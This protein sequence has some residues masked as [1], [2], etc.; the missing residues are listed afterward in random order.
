MNSK[1]LGV[2]LEVL[3]NSLILAIL[4]SAA[5]LLFSDIKDVKDALKIFLG[6]LIFGVL[7]AYIC[8]EWTLL[9]GYLRTV[10][11]LASLAGKELYDLTI[12][13]VRNPAVLFEII[14]AVKGIK[15]EED[16]DVK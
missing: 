15:K 13:I 6:G 16:K 10:I 5:R 8:N 7:A 12:S 4:A 11:I 2:T 9:R 14:K 1:Y 3:V